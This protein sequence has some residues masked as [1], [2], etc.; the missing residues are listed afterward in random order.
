MAHNWNSIAAV[1]SAKISSLLFL[2]LTTGP[3][4]FMASPALVFATPVYPG[5]IVLAI[6]SKILHI[7]DSLTLTAL[8]SCKEQF[9]IVTFYCL[10]VITYK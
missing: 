5:A 4:I 2:A 10:V 7:F 8:I 3:V 6:I 9:F 1:M